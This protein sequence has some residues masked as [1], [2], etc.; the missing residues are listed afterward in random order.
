MSK[1]SVKGTKTEQNLLKA[2]AGESQARSRY[3]M[4]AAI[5]RKEG[6]VQ[7]ADFFLET[8]ENEYMH[9]KT[10][11]RHLEGGPVEI[12]AMYPAGIE[13]T[14]PEN[15]K[16][17]AEG[18]KE[19][20]DV[21]Y[22]EFARVAKEEGFPEIAESFEYIASVEVAHEARFLTLLD[23]I[24]KNKV[25]KRE[26]KVIWKCGVCGYLQEGYE[27]PEMCP[28]CDHAKKYFAIKEENY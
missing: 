24:E 26:N 28:S 8:A 21:L 11:F 19:E 15:L 13:S 27:P 25:F 23:N 22:P 3:E 14:T 2:F 16:A 7:I 9:A 6:Y 20:Y 4:F 17:A 12:T 5:A 1:K 18:E 10:F